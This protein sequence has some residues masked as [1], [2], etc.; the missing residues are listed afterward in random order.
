MDMKYLIQVVY[1]DLDKRKQVGYLCYN[2]LK[3]WYY[4]THE[5]LSCNLD[6]LRKEH[7]LSE[8]QENMKFI[9]NDVGRINNR[10]IVSVGIVAV[11]ARVVDYHEVRMNLV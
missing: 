4:L 1:D 6:Y 11:E 9:I 3:E 7:A 5:L 10:K 8:I 2:W